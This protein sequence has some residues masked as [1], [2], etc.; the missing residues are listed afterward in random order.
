MLKPGV[1]PEVAARVLLALV[2]GLQLQ[3]LYERDSV[4]VADDH[5]ERFRG[6]AH[7]QSG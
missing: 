5:P 6:P 3:W 2:D 7:G 1:S 4:K